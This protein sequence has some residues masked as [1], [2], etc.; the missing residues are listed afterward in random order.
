MVAGGLGVG[1]VL[2]WGPVGVGCGSRGAPGLGFW[3]GVGW[4]WQAS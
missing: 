3:L 2:A 1:V 4:V